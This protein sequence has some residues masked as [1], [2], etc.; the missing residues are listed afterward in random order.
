MNL[1]LILR[2]VL[3]FLISF[4][5]VAQRFAIIGDYGVDNSN[6]LEVSQLV[7]NWNPEFILTVGDN[8]YGRGEDSTIDVNIGKYYSD[9]IHPYKGDFGS[10]SGTIKFF[11][12]PGNH[13]YYTDEGRPYYNYFELPGN[14]RYYEFI[15]GDIHFF[16]LNSNRAEPDGNEVDSKQ[17]VWLRKKLASSNK[18]WKIVY[19]HHT[20]Y[21]SG[22]HGSNKNLQWPF[23]DWGASAVVYGHDHHYE[24]FEISGIPYFLNGSGGQE[25][26]PIIESPIEESKIIYD[27]EHGAMFVSASSNQITFK[28]RSVENEVRDSYTIRTNESQEDSIENKNLD[29]RIFTIIDGLQDVEENETD[30][31][32][33]VNSLDLEFGFDSYNNQNYQT[34]GLRFV[35]VKIPAYRKI[36]KAYLRMVAKSSGSGKS[37]IKFHGEATGNSLAFDVNNS[38]ELTTRNFTENSIEWSPLNWTADELINSPDLSEILKEIIK[39]PNWEYGNAIS[40][41]VEVSKSSL[42]IK[43]YEGSDGKEAVELV[44]ELETSEEAICDAPIIPEYRIN[45]DWQC[46]KN[47]LSI[48]EGS[49]FI[50]SSQPNN[51]KLSIELPNGEIVTDSYKIIHL[52]TSDSGTYT[53]HNAS[54]CTAKVYLKVEKSNR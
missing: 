49:N 17:A 53:L 35:D 43:S 45:G 16:S 27:K 30:G 41:F 28:F 40:L 51:K 13:D 31:Q 22:Y 42:N 46:G 2:I 29:E 4:S 39:H 9:Y 14:E 7:K 54:G 15:R 36:V 18:K 23:A 44:V 25:L 33:Y 12:S 34:V 1:K 47:K 19:L 50:L 5:S 26:R 20:V 3:P 10:G 32:L 6:E 52:K 38:N 48:Y 37:H 11:P 24:R 21:S 8:N